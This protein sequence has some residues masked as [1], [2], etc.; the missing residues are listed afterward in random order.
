MHKLLE[1]VK[2][3]FFKGKKKKKTI[4]QAEGINT[5]L[6]YP[7]STQLELISSVDLILLA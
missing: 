7:P 1:N 2:S 3:F 5:S 4:F 6:S